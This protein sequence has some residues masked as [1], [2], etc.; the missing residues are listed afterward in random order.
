MNQDKNIF[1]IANIV[2]AVAQGGHLTL[3]GFV[4]N[5]FFYSLTGPDFIYEIIYSI[6]R[7]RNETYSEKD[8]LV[9]KIVD[10]KVITYR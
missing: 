10:H 3:N 6:K 7:Q 5:T 4:G 2:I 8:K 1:S 9:I